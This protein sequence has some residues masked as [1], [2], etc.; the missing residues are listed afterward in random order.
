MSFLEQPGSQAYEGQIAFRVDPEYRR[1]APTGPNVPWRVQVPEPMREDPGTAQEEGQS[2][3][4][5]NSPHPRIS[6]A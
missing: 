2:E 3:E 6:S 5:G 1:A 4:A